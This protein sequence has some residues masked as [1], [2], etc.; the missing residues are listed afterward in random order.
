MWSVAPGDY[1]TFSSSLLFDDIYDKSNFLF[2]A[3]FDDY[4]LQVSDYKI[5]SLFFR[6]Y[7]EYSLLFNLF[8][9]SPGY[10]LFKITISSTFFCS[11]DFLKS[12]TIYV[13]KKFC[14]VTILKYSRIS[15][16]IRISFI[17]K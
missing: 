13:T 10:S 14:S 12:F 1:N 8:P 15:W 2:V 16:F 17:T 3:R 9:G 5:S 6:N 4:T 11:S 7:N